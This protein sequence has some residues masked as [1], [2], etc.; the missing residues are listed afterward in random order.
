MQTQHLL[1]YNLHPWTYILISVL[2]VVMSACESSQPIK[3]VDRVVMIQGVCSS[4]ESS[5]NLT[6][7][8]TNIKRLLVEDFGLIDMPTGH[9]DDQVIEF[10]YSEDGWDSSYLPADTLN[11]VQES[12]AALRDIYS[13]YPDSRIFIIGHSL[14]GI[15]A[16]DGLARYSNNENRMKSRTAGLITV[17]SPVNG[18]SELAVDVARIAIEL[19]AC[20]IEPSLAQ[21][22]SPVWADLQVRGDSISLIRESTW[23]DVRVVNFANKAD[24][25]VDWQSA[26]LMTHFEVSC[27]N[28]RSTNFFDGNHDTLLVNTELSQELLDV[29]LKEDIPR[30]RC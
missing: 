19:V 14:G 8:T 28:T 20:R 26:I 29:L 4:T 3:Q 10:G 30:Y 2:V 11:S 17:S 27:Y 6:A 23:D 21:Y 24:R 7:W 9:P 18:L 1:K 12:S 13:A 15:V 16:L 5:S 25:V 22:P